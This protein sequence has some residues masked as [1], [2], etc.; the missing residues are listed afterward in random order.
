LQ[1]IQFIREQRPTFKTFRVALNSKIQE[2]EQVVWLSPPV[3]P[4]KQIPVFAAIPKGDK[5][6]T[7]SQMPESFD[8]QQSKK[9]SIKIRVG[10]KAKGV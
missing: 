5:T 9:F 6:S 2:N 8:K 7:K 1:E 3:K 10:G 4:I